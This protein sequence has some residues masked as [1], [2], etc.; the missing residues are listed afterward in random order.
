MVIFYSMHV[1]LRVNIPH[2]IF[3]KKTYQFGIFGKKIIVIVSTFKKSSILIFMASHNTLF[4][5]CIAFFTKETT[6]YKVFISM[7]KLQ[8]HDHFLCSYCII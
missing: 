1:L 6:M 5:I 3:Q 7:N 4:I 2:F 8:V